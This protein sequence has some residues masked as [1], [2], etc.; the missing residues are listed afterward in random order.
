MNS[1]FVEILLGETQGSIA[2]SI[3]SPFSLR[4]SSRTQSI[5]L[6]ETKSLAPVLL[7]LNK[8]A[9]YLEVFRDGSLKL[10]MADGRT[11]T[12]SKAGTAETW[13]ASGTEHLQELQPAKE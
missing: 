8:E 6:A 1:S 10:A 12:V 4:H 3:S 2:I 5:D 13:F 7:L 9:K 11:L